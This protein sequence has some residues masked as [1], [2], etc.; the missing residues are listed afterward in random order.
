LGKT[1]IP[2]NFCPKIAVISGPL[3]ELQG[4]TKRFKWTQLH[5]ESFNQCKKIIQSNRV[6]KPINHELGEPIYLVT[7]ASNSAI[8]G[9]IRQ[10]DSTGKVRPVQF[11]L[12]KLN[13]TQFHYCKESVFSPMSYRVISA[14]LRTFTPFL[15]RYNCVMT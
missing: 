5:E 2:D 10:Y 9:W 1:Q 7:D 6:L 15:Q 3:S 11:H 13:P 14:Y 4:E 12:R 8:A